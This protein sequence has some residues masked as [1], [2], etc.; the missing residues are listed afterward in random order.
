MSLKKSIA[1]LVL[2][3]MIFSYVPINAIIVPTNQKSFI[4]YLDDIG[5]PTESLAGKPAWYETYRDYGHLVVYGTPW[6]PEGKKYNDKTKT[7]EYRYLGYTVNDQPYTNSKFPND[8]DGGKTPLQWIYENVNGAELSWGNLSVE[9]REHMRTANLK[10]ENTPYSGLTVNWIGTT[11]PKP[12]LRG[13]DRQS[14]LQSPASW[15]NGFSVYT[16]HKGA[17]GKLYYATFYG[18]DMGGGTNVDCSISTP[19]NTYTIK[20]DQLSVSVPVTVTATAKLEGTYVKP[21]HIQ[22]L[23]A[24]FLDSKNEV[25]GPTTSA[26]A[27]KDH[28]ISRSQFSSPGSYTI[29]LTGNAE[30]QSTL[31]K[32]DY[33]NKQ[34]TKTIIVIVEGNPNA[35]VEV[36][37]TADPAK[38]QVDGSKDELVT[39]IVTATLKNYTD[40]TNIKEWKIFAKLDGEDLTLQTKL[41]PGGV[42][43]SSAT[44]NFTVIKGKFNVDNFL[45]SFKATGVVYLHRA[46]GPD[47][48]YEGTNYTTSEFYKVGP[49]PDPF[50][51]PEPPLDTNIKP[52]AVLNYEETVKA[53]DETMVDVLSS[54]D[55]DGYI[56]EYN[57]YTPGANII[58]N[59]EGQATVWYPYKGKITY[60][61][62]VAGRVK[63][64]KGAA[65]GKTEYI[66][67]VEPTID[68]KINVTGKLKENRHVTIKN[69]SKSPTHY[70]IDN[71]K[72]VW[73]LEAVSGGT[74]ADIK[75]NGVLRSVDTLNVIFKK[76]GVYRATLNV[77]NTL[78]Y[79]GT[80]TYLINIGPDL[81]PIANFATATTVLRD[82]KDYGNA[83]I[84]L[85]DMSY[86]LDGDP[87]S[88]R[89]WSYAFDSNNNGS[90]ADETYVVFDNGNNTKPT[91][92]VSTVGKYHI[93]LVAQE[94]FTDT[95]TLYILPSDYLSDDTLDK[96]LAESVVEV[97][98]IAPTT[99]FSMINKKKVDLIFN[100][101]DTKHTVSEVLSKI[102]S[103][104][105]PAMSENN[106]DAQITV[107]K[108]YNLLYNY[109]PYNATWTVGSQAE[110]NP[111][112]PEDEDGTPAYKKLYDL[113]AGYTSYSYNS[114][115]SRTFYLGNYSTN[116]I[117][118]NGDM[119]YLNK[120]DSR[121]AY[122]AFYLY[123]RAGKSFQIAYTCSVENPSTGLI[124]VGSQTYSKSPVL[125]NVD[126][127]SRLY[128]KSFRTE[129]NQLYLTATGIFENWT[130]GFN[131]SG[132]A[133]VLE[134]ADK[135]FT[136]TPTG[137][138]M[139]NLSHIGSFTYVP[140]QYNGN[141]NGRADVVQL[142]T[143][144]SINDTSKYMETLLSEY[145]PRTNSKPY[146]ITIADNQLKE[147]SEPVRASKVLTQTLEKNIN[148]AA[149]GTTINKTQLENFKISNNNNGT[150]IDNTNLDTVITGLKNYILGI[151]NQEEPKTKYVLMGEDLEYLT[152]YDDYED[153]IKNA[154]QWSFT[155]T[156]P[157][158]FDNPLGLDPQSGINRTSPM[159]RFERVG[160]YD[161]LLRVQDNPYNNSLFN[162]YKLW[163][164]DDAIQLIVHRRPIADFTPYVMFNNTTSKYYI[165]NVDKSYD[166]DHSVSRVDKGIVQKVW[167]WKLAED[168]TWQSGIPTEIL[169]GKTYVL[170]L[171]VQD[172]EGA[173]SLPA[174]EVITVP[175]LLIYANPTNLPWQNTNAVVNLGVK[176]NA[177][178]F[179]R[180]DYM[181][182]NSITKPTSGW[183][184]STSISNNLTQ[185]ATGAWYLHATAYTTTGENVY[186]YFG[187]Y[188]IDKIAP[189]ITNSVTTRT[190]SDP[191]VA[192]ITINDTGGSGIRD[193]KYRWTNS[194]TKPTS[195]WVTAA[196]SLSTT[197]TQDGTWYLHVETTDNAGNITY[198]NFG[199]Y[200]VESLDITSTSIIGSWNHWR[201]QIDIL[202]KRLTVDPHRFLSYE[203]VTFR[204][205]TIGVPNSVSVRLSPELEAMTYIDPTGN[206]YSYSDAVGSNVNFPIQLTSTDGGNTWTGSYILP[207]ARNTL[208]KD[209]NRKRTSYKV[210]FTATK[211]AIT[212]TD[213]I[214]DIELTGSIY[215]YIYIQPEN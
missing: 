15:K 168:V 132:G 126:M 145:T 10:F 6:G 160:T 172:M 41:N 164:K 4:E 17:N 26:T 40:T 56:T 121:N 84:E 22:Y 38:K 175:D 166:L 32:S 142:G 91:L 176:V 87:I 111:N 190:N 136:I 187:P 184:S 144:T 202:G 185:S 86:S 122:Q 62:R 92:K 182:T 55:P 205:V 8:V 118:V 186:N 137:I 43:S 70:P 116:P 24:S 131:G 82:I 25:V 203:K 85:T 28:V 174:S 115:A 75:F 89:V 11:N 2:F 30:L 101:W 1:F 58:D 153:D 206:R 100:V 152:F 45:Q 46:I 5:T 54:Y 113:P 103:T 112:D 210:T 29:T 107:N 194:V 212:R 37:A 106:I 76:Q 199:S 49:A 178:V 90:F 83:K 108:N 99:A 167:K 154:E 77:T 193:I 79:T 16:Q 147:L 71:S 73:T 192:N 120:T 94:S 63:D 209:D 169:Y 21:T 149:L 163:S 170:Q 171:M 119:Y 53:G 61:E 19:A 60:K 48:F 47:N 44:Y 109:T 129:G 179:S 214:T 208:D 13:Y 110:A 197:Q 165:S 138:D 57:V 104:I 188:Q 143:L 96:P 7:F 9:Q 18:P 93:K 31:S 50:P 191:I 23:R 150:F 180:V 27:T 51:T 196:G 156:N 12:E 97:I 33:Y 189:T 105:V 74:N 139:N 162:N 34:A 65:N 161:A 183:T 80:A 114:T 102:N 198:R 211:G 157:N 200:I 98:N 181:W 20:A 78:G 135:E 125:K 158:Y 201:G 95:L 148:F 155:H 67:V 140:R 69:V 123:D 133:N 36:T 213:E 68:A 134:F 215:D 146:L 207:L 159:T 141:N 151:E 88:S 117:T 195:G 3:I 39:V 64:N 204:V 72:T 35:Y 130:S 177:G 127:E 14:K 42:L 128:I 173:W 66:T 59:N 124:S 81:K 52:V